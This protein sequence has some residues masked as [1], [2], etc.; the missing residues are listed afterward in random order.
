MQAKYI[1]K[2]EAEF[3]PLEGFK[4]DVQSALFGAFVSALRQK[5]QEVIVE[6]KYKTYAGT[7]DTPDRKM[8]RY[9][10]ARHIHNGL[11]PYVV[12]TCFREDTNA[13]ACPYV[14]DIITRGLVTELPHW[15]RHRYSLEHKNDKQ[16]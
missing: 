11:V 5:E 7:K 4:A 3:G 12:C 13:V 1:K 15:W 8:K 14:P 6:A 2:F 16:K 10:Y 9:R